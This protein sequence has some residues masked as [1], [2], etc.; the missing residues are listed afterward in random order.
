MFLV[1]LDKIV[2]DILYVGNNF[3]IR[4]VFTKNSC[5]NFERVNFLKKNFFIFLGKLSN[6]PYFFLYFF[7]KKCLILF[8][9]IFKIGKKFK[10]LKF[11]KVSTLEL[12][13]LK[14]SEK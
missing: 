4:N 13:K 7:F 6:F 5:L 10:F 9:L 12:F 11:F 2:L 1:K 8:E 3:S 14:K